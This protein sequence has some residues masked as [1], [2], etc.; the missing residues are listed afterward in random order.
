MQLAGEDKLK[1]Q[2]SILTEEEMRSPIFKGYLKEMI[3]VM[4]DLFAT[5]MAAIQVGWPKKVIIIGAKDLSRYDV[6]INAT[7]KP[8][9][10]HGT[11]NSIENSINF[12]KKQFS[13]T[14]WNTIKVSYSGIFNNKWKTFSKKFRFES[15]LQQLIDLT[16]GISL[17]NK[18]SYF[19]EYK[20]DIDIPS[21]TYLKYYGEDLNG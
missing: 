13:L 3:T 18:G 1:I 7:Y 8:I 19:G 10:R 17:K 14:R 4:Q 21:K 20:P 15:N 9:K 5:G 2:S 6:F 12:P 11:F 16:N